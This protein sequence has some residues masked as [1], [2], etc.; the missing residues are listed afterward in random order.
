MAVFTIF[1]HGTA[2]NR[3]KSDDSGEVVGQLS[4]LMDGEE[5]RFTGDGLVRGNYLIN[6][7][8]GSTAGGLDQPSVKNPFTGQDKGQKTGSKFA[9]GFYGETSKHWAATGLISGADWEDNTWRAAHTVQSLKFD[10]DVDITTVNLTGWSRGGVTC[11][12]IANML[13]EVFGDSIRVNIFAYDP[14]A[15]QDAGLQPINRTLPSNVDKFVAILAMH[16]RRKTFKPQDLS[17]VIVKEPT[18]TQVTFLPFPGTHGEQVMSSTHYQEPAQVARSLGYALLQQW[19]TPF[20]GMPRGPLL[21]N[22][23]MLEAYSA[24]SQELAKGHDSVYYKHETSGIKAR[25]MGKGLG[26]RSFYTSKEMDKYVA[27]GK[28]LAAFS[29]K[30]LLVPVTAK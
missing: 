21:T 6:E 18:R 25:L 30:D 26:R 20:D 27:G 28:G 2:F 17:R 1:N 3:H 16:E 15:G 5:V 24:M 19:G 10:H 4:Q 14:V 12:R 11:I 8:P 13:Y 7:G 23:A 29:A 9:K 22:A